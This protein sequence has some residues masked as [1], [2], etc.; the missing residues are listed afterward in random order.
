[1]YVTDIWKDAASKDNRKRGKYRLYWRSKL[2]IEIER[3][4]TEHVIFV[5]EKARSNGWEYATAAGKD[6]DSIVFPSWRKTRIRR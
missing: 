1:V 2:K 6:Y 5:G 4:V 3:V